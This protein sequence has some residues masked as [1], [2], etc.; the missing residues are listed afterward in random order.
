[1]ESFVLVA[2]HVGLGMLIWDCVEVGR[3]DAA[4]LINAVFG[5][6]VMRRRTAVFVAGAAVVLGATFAS[7]V[8]ETVRK[9]IFEP[10]RLSLEAVI[11]VYISVYIVDTVLLYVFSAF[12]MPVSTT[13][14]LVF[15]LVGAAVGVGLASFGVGD[16]LAVVYWPKV[17]QVALAIASSIVLSGCAGFLIQRAFRGAIRNDAADPDRVALHGPWIAGLMLTWLGW[18]MLLKGF[19]GVAL[20]SWIQQTILERYGIFPV[21]VFSWFVCTMTVQLG[22]MA[23]KEAGTR[24]L[25]PTMA[26]LGMVCMAFAFGQNDLANCASPGLSAWWLHQNAHHSVSAATAIPIPHWALFGC[27]VLMAMGMSTRTAQRVTRAAVNTGSQFD[28]VALWAPRWCR[29]V[30]RLVVRVGPPAADIAPPS[31]LTGGKKVHYDS[32]RASVIMSVSASV[33][34]FA[35][36]RG[37]PVSTTYVAFAAVVAT[38]WGDRIFQR[39]DAELKMGR[40]I[41]V[42]VS[43]VMAAMI[44][45]VAAGVV[46]FAIFRLSLLGLALTL[47][48][49]LGVRFY[50]K[51]RADSHEERYHLHAE[52]TGGAEPEQAE[53]PFD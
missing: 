18:F 28:R 42:A 21:L 20:A 33:I 37:L 40:A 46:A 1:M 51:R 32:L 50:F 48:A 5:A 9:G 34:A 53:L 35:S 4:N 13:A 22:L 38:G 26:V 19:Q 16:A 3:N 27:G 6:R 49:N 23:M 10:G 43:W 2:V 12:G 45:T 31:M 24:L 25:F 15:S 36:S 30:A 11:A 52:P 8:M 39:G 47:G 7:P 44:A 29:A 14:T 17:A 41:W